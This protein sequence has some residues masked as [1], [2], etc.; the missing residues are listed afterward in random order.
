MLFPLNSAEP[1]AGWLGPGMGTSGNILDILR[2]SSGFRIKH[3]P[4]AKWMQRKGAK[5]KT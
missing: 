1:G 3:L 2:N 4:V 5:E